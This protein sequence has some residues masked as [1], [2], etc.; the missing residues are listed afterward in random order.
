M[1]GPHG[2]TAVCSACSSEST[3]VYL[4]LADQFGGGVL[5]EPTLVIKTI[6]GGDK[7]IL[8]LTIQQGDLDEPK[9]I[10]VEGL[11]FEAASV[12]EAT[13]DFK[14]NFGSGP[15]SSSDVLIIEP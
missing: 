7:K 12:K 4:D 11:P 13:I 6:N 2:G 9:T 3:T 1:S 5:S 10:V 8:P 15:Y 14:V